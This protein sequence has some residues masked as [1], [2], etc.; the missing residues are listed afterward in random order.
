MILGRSGMI[1]YLALLYK[2]LSEWTRSRGLSMVVYVMKTVVP[3]VQQKLQSRCERLSSKPASEFVTKIQEQVHMT[4]LE[5]LNHLAVSQ[6]DLYGRCISAYHYEYLTAHSTFFQTAIKKYPPFVQCN[7]YSFREK[8]DYVMYTIPHQL[9][10]LRSIFHNNFG[11]THNDYNYEDEQDAKIL[12]NFVDGLNSMSQTMLLYQNNAIDCHN[13][14]QNLKQFIESLESIIP[15]I[16]CSQSLINSLTQ[17]I[18]VIK[19]KHVLCTT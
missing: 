18:D 17:S 3:W 15:V 7:V 14:Q 4:I 9:R 11:S 5:Y 19:K 12:W 1:L 8:H 16:K 6:A 10:Y 13:V 2:G